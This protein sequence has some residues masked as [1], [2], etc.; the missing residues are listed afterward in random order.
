[1]KACFTEHPLGDGK[2]VIALS[3]GHCSSI[4]F[5]LLQHYCHKYSY[6]YGDV[7]VDESFYLE[8]LIQYSH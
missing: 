2:E 4:P 5:S 3:G 1:M 6:T 8:G 7:Q